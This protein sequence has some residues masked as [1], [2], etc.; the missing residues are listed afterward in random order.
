MKENQTMPEEQADIKE[1]KATGC[2][3]H[4]RSSQVLAI[5]NKLFNVMGKP[6]P[7]MKKMRII[8]V[9]KNRFKRLKNLK[10]NKT[11]LDDYSIFKHTPVHYL[12]VK[13]DIL[14]LLFQNGIVRAR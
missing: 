8:P 11:L 7:R 12:F 6:S 4:Q 2:S 13:F 14:T 10:S 5:E 9:Q 3:S 1:K